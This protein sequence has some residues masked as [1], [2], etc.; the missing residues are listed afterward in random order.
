MNLL[1]TCPVTTAPL[2]STKH[3]TAHTHIKYIV[4]TYHAHGMHTAHTHSTNALHST[5]CISIPLPSTQRRSAK[6]HHTTNHSY[7][8]HSIPRHSTPQLST[9]LHYALR[10]SSPT[11]QPTPIHYT[12]PP[13]ILPQ[14]HTTALQDILVFPRQS[15]PRPVTSAAPLP[16]QSEILRGRR[17]GVSL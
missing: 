8:I 2:S 15:H 14:T 12:Q 11:L 1:Y 6:L 5:Q 9:P 10:H 17:N 13:C 16:R 3:N 7:P 4:L